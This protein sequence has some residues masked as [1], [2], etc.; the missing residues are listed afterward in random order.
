MHS[1]PM[2]DD[3]CSLEWE[4]IFNFAKLKKTLQ[5]DRALRCF[6]SHFRV[7][8]LPKTPFFIYNGEISFLY[9]LNTY[10]RL[11]FFSWVEFLHYPTQKC[12]RSFVRI[13]H[14]HC[15][16]R[17]FLCVFRALADGANQIIRRTPDTRQ[18][19]FL[20]LVPWIR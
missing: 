18:S 1:G 9:N 12:F 14:F 20:L 13:Q 15:L 8:R 19:S 5:L 4:I 6:F 10:F 7:T 11:S 16:S 2:Q 17:H 3:I